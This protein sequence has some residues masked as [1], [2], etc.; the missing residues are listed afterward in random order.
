MVGFVCACDWKQRAVLSSPSRTNRRSVRAAVV[1]ARADGRAA[2]QRPVAPK[3]RRTTRETERHERTRISNNTRWGCFFNAEGSKRKERFIIISLSLPPCLPC[4][5]RR[6]RRGSARAPP[7][8]TREPRPKKK[9]RLLFFARARPKRMIF[10]R[11]GRKETSARDP[12][13]GDEFCRAP[14]CRAPPN[15]RRPRALLDRPPP[16][17]ARGGDCRASGRGSTRRV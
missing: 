7:P 11:A 3:T 9:G 13:G 14:F 17:K 2:A 6:R 10:C 15:P 5:A 1:V 4:L 8:K 12:P 16:K